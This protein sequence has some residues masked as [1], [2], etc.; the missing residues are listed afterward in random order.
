MEI[1]YSALPESPHIPNVNSEFQSEEH[2]EP[3]SATAVLAVAAHIRSFYRLFV[4]ILALLM[5]SSVGT[6]AI[7]MGYMKS[8]SCPSSRIMSRWLRLFGIVDL[9][10]CGF[11]ATIVCTFSF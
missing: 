9:I 6:A 2:D 1:L 11:I 5:I 7:V 10:M 8:N 4:I 3:H